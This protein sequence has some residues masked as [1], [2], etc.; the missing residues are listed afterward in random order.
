MFNDE[1]YLPRNLALLECS[2]GLIQFNDNERST[3]LRLGFLF[4]AISLRVSEGMNSVRNYN[5]VASTSKSSYL[6]SKRKGRHFLKTYGQLQS[7]P[8]GDTVGVKHC[9]T[10]KTKSLLKGIF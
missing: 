9:V 5:R 6:R 1:C 10:F 2:N 8:V 3:F 7:L 4:C